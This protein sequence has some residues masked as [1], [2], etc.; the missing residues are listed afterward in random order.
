MSIVLPLPAVP[1]LAVSIAVGAV[2]GVVVGLLVDPVLVDAVSLEEPHA[3]S[4]T[5][6]DDPAAI[7]RRR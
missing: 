2:V 5:S 4:R 7:S 6:N 3:A 1:R